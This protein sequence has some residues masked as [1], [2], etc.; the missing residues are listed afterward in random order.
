MNLSCNY[1][2]PQ[3]KEALHWLQVEMWEHITEVLA[4]L[5]PAA[6]DIDDESFGEKPDDPDKLVEYEGMLVSVAAAQ[7]RR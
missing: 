2:R 3:G 6:V 7:R 5:G 4:Q 1:S